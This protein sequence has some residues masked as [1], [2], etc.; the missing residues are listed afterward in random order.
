MC[1]EAKCTD[2]RCAAHPNAA[3]V[4]ATECA[5]AGECF[6]Q[7][8]QADGSCK[9]IPKPSN[10]SCSET[11]TDQCNVGMCDTNGTCVT[12][13][14]NDVAS[15]GPEEKLK[16][17][18]VTLCQDFKCLAGQCTSVPRVAGTNCTHRVNESD[19]TEVICFV[20]LCDGSGMCVTNQ[21][22][23]VCVSKK[24]GKATAAIVG[25]TVAVIALVAVGVFV[26]AKASPAVAAGLGMDPAFSAAAV[27]PTYVQMADNFNPTY[28]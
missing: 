12:V 11:K 23:S 22:A 13:P 18:N 1:E 10:I 20:S 27:N 8:C 21:T 15:V 2:G 19:A 26:A 14:L 24:K 7:L 5:A 17:R 25:G 3:A 28:N 9:K 16:D 4:N 6:T